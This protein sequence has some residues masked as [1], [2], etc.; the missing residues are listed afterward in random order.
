MSQP[1]R[2]A[3]F[4]VIISG[5]FWVTA[6]AVENL[7]TKTCELFNYSSHGTGG[8]TAQTI[9]VCGAKTIV[10]MTVEVIGSAERSTNVEIEIGQIRESQK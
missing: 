5:R 3:G 8:G 1:L 6:K 9:A 2:V 7:D 4:E 10:L